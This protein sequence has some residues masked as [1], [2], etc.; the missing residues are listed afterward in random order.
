M[1]KS[2]AAPTSQGNIYTQ[3]NDDG[4]W[5]AWTMGDCMAVSALEDVTLRHVE[6]HA[7]LNGTGEALAHRD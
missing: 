1:S 4:A 2:K 3:K 7:R 6:D 5:C